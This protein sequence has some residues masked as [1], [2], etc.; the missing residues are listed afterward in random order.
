MYFPENTTPEQRSTRLSAFTKENLD[1]LGAYAIALGLGKDSKKG[2]GKINAIAFKQDQTGSLSEAIKHFS[3]G[4]P[5]ISISLKHY[6]DKI[7][8]ISDPKSPKEQNFWLK[9]TH[10]SAYRHFGK[11]FKV[12]V[13]TLQRQL[14]NQAK[15]LPIRI[16][17]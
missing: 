12:Q 16:H 8:A 3:N 15:I 10:F 4:S 6:Q 1:H 9:E 13:Q 7:D 5:A 14:Q 17:H 2:K 11:S